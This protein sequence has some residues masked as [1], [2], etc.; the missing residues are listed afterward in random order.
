MKPEYQLSFTPKTSET[1]AP[2]ARQVLEA[3]KAEMGFIP[4]FYALIANAPTLLASYQQSYASFREGSHF[5]P[6]EQEV[7]FL[8]ISRENTCHYCVA[9]HSCVADS[10][11]KVPVDITDAIRNEKQIP[12]TRLKALSDFVRSMVETRGRPAR[13]DVAAFLQASYTEENILEVIL[14]IAIKTMSNYANHLL[15]TPLD[16]VF[17]ARAWEHEEA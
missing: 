17:Q 8:T 6:P 14:A 11:S 5:T 13:R 9:A 4:N 15:D 12:D 7:I 3:A 10:A 16:E 2:L 1:A